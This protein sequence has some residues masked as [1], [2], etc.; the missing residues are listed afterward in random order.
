MEGTLI[1]IEHL[2]DSV[3]VMDHIGAKDE[4]SRSRSQSPSD[5]AILVGS[6]TS[7]RGRK[8][9]ASTT[10]DPESHSKAARALP[11]AKRWDIAATKIHNGKMASVFSRILQRN[12]KFPKWVYEID[13]Y[14]PCDDCA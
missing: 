9:T 11:V 1:K 8:R 14:P 4:P 5:G 6:G 10:L 2:D 12:S 7:R 3:I 13:Q